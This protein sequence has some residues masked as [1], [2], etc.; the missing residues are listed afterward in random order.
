M[1]PDYNI[2]VPRKQLVVGVQEYYEASFETFGAVAKGVDWNGEDGQA[3][4]F[5]QI[6][7]SMR[8][9]DTFSICDFGC[10]YGAFA[11]YL[12]DRGFKGKYTG[13]DI[14]GSMVDYASK[15]YSHTEQFSFLQRDKPVTADLIVASG[16]FNVIPINLSN[17]WS[18][19]VWELITDM[20]NKSNVKI[21]FNLLLPPTTGYK[22]KENL[23]S[24]S[25]EQV[26]FNL[27][28]NLKGEFRVNQLL[29][30]KLHEVTY[31]II[32]N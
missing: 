28:N 19:Y 16:V 5:T 10:G 8:F 21:V 13:V 9:I 25:P 3:L 23:Y 4:R 31:E 14:V 29:N 11:D 6:A 24:L 32:K 20:W 2:K 17:L 15:R 7:S 30:Y 22:R 26:N 27:K 18:E 12:K 1:N